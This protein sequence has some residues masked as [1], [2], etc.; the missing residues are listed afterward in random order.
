LTEHRVGLQQYC[1]VEQVLIIGSIG[2][3]TDLLANYMEM[4]EED[5][6][7]EMKMF[8]R[9]CTASYAANCVAIISSTVPED[10]AEFPNVC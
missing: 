1:I 9:K 4:D 3:C 2:K 10:R 8:H 7:A 6:S 5:M